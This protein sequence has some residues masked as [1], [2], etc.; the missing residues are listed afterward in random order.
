VLV[1]PNTPLTQN[2]GGL[3]PTLQAPSTLSHSAKQ[4]KLAVI[5]LPVPRA[6]QTKASSETAKPRRPAICNAGQVA[7]ISRRRS[8][9]V[10]V[11][12]VGAVVSPRRMNGKK[13][14]PKS[15]ALPLNF[16]LGCSEKSLGNFELA[17]LA[18]EA[19]LRNG[20][21][22]I[23]DRL[24]DQMSQA[25]LTA[26]FRKTDRE[27]LKQALEIA[28]T[29]SPWRKSRSETGSAAKTLILPTQK[30]EL[31]ELLRTNNSR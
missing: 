14:L 30:N 27:T 6:A 24:I 2:T 12:R 3:S 23:L 7:G 10:Y 21:H 29:L 22:S 26:W 8:A 11:G 28:M 20:L 5:P 9:V 17:R 25:A 19:D 15:L 18:D 4:S 31:F 1:T 16:L 13:S